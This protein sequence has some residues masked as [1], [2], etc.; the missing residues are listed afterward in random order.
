MSHIALKVS[1]RLTADGRHNTARPESEDR[2]RCRIL[3]IRQLALG[4]SEALW[5]QASNSRL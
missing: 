4:H 3:A 2:V 5:Q 1:D